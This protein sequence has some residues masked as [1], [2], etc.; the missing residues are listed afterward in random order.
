M[1]PVGLSNDPGYYGGMTEPFARDAEIAGMGRRFVAITLDWLMSWAVGSLIFE[2]SEGR[3]LW[4]PAVFFLQIVLLTWLTGSSA[5]QRVLGLSVRSYPDMLPLG[6]ARVV[7][8]TLLI[9]LV[10][11]AV[12]FDTEGR[13]LHDRIAKSAVYRRV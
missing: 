6:F 11:P 3:A 7:L 1:F 9:L 10:I 8:R 2:Q 13:G 4:I 5:G 12:V